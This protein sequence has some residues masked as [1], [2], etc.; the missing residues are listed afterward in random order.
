MRQ[1][2][3]LRQFQRALGA[4]GRW[5]MATEQDPS[6]PMDRHLLDKWLGKAEANAKLPKLDGSLWHAYR[7]KWATE[8]RN[9]PLTDVAAAG[10]WQNSATLLRCYQQR[11]NDALLVVMS[12]ATKMRDVAVCAR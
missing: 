9:L 6:F 2:G 1:S 3:E 12:E 10:G 4:V 11:R 5:F 8:R 7:R